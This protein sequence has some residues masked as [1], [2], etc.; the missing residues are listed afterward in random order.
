MIIDLN[1]S[2]AFSSQK[3]SPFF[4]NLMRVLHNLVN[5]PQRLTNSKPNPKMPNLIY[6]VQKTCKSVPI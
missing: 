1:A 2:I 5:D 3:T 6:Q 4:M